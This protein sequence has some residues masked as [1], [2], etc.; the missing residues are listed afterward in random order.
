MPDVTNQD[1]CK[2]AMAAV[3]TFA[4]VTGLDTAPEADGLQ[5]AIVDLL[6]DLMHLCDANGLQLHELMPSAERHYAAERWGE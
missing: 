1:R 6:A 3:Q 5:T 2:W 4:G